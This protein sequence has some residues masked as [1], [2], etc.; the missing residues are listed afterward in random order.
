MWPWLNTTSCL[1]YKQQI[2]LGNKTALAIGCTEMQILSLASL[3][4]ERFWVISGNVWGL[5]YL[6]KQWKKSFFDTYKYE[7]MLY[8]SS[9]IK[10]DLLLGEIIVKIAHQVCGDRNQN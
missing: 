4:H 3:E 6:L 10:P 1:L 9:M 2:K 7:W 8:V 5:M